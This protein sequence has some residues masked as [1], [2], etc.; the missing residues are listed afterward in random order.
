MDDDEQGRLFDPER[1]SPIRVDAILRLPSGT[2]QAFWIASTL[3][4]FLRFDG[5]S[6]R[7]K[8]AKEAAGTLVRPKQRAVILK[9]LGIGLRRWEQHVREWERRNVAHACSRGDVFLFAHALLDVC[10]ACH[11]YVEVVEMPPPPKR[12]RGPGFARNLSPRSAETFRL[13][14]T[15]LSPSSVQTF[16]LS[17]TDAPHQNAGL[18]R[19]EVGTPSPPGGPEPSEDSSKQGV[20][21]KSRA[22]GKRIAAKITR[23]QRALEAIPSDEKRRRR[24]G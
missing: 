8:S 7:L 4:R 1:Y 2:T 9:V 20:G 12:R 24:R 22:D 17:G 3:G 19:A 11:R 6:E 23:S 16:R 10:P 15:N 18:L 21:T 5:G 13:T 14:R